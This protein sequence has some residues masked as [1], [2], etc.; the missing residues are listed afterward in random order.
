MKQKLLLLLLL[1]S[2]SLGLYAQPGSLDASFD[3]GTG[4]NQFLFSSA[5][6]PDG[7][8]IIGGRFTSYNGTTRNSIARLNDDGSLDTSFD[9]G[10]GANQFV[11]TSTLQPDGKIIIGGA[12]TSYG[13]TALNYIARLNADGSLDTS[14]DP[15]T[16]ADGVVIVAAIQPDGKI[17]IAG[18]F[19]SYNGT[20]RNKIARLNADGS[21]DTSF[22][23]GT[24]ADELILTA[25]L[26]S[27][28]KIIIG[29]R[30]TSYDGRTRN[31]IARLNDDGSL[32]TS[33][34]ADADGEVRTT[35]IQSNGKI[36]IGGSF[37]SYNGTP[38]NRSARL[39][40]DGSLDTS[41]DPGTGP[42]SDILIT[43][44]Q[45][46]G[47]V[48]IGGVFT[49]FGGTARNFVARLNDD[50]S[51]DTSFDTG[52]KAN[53]QVRTAAVQSDGKIIIG[54]FFTSYDGTTRNRIARLNGEDC[55]STPI[56]CPSNV[57]QSNDSGD[58]GAVVNFTLPTGAT[59]TPSSGSFFPVGIATVNVEG[60]DGCGETSTCSFTVTINDTEKPSISCPSNTT[61]GT[62]DGECGADLVLPAPDAD[63]NCGVTQLRGRYRLVDE[64]DNPLGSYT[65]RMDDPSGYLAV[66]RYQINWRAKD[67]ANNKRSCSY[68]LTVED[69]E[70]PSAICQDVV[71]EFNGE[72]SIDLAVSQVWNEAASDDNCGLVSYVDTSPSLSI[73]C[74]DLGSIVPLTVTISDEA[75]NTA[76]CTAAVTVIG[77]PCGSS[78][79]ADN[80]SLNCL[81][82]TD[83]AYDIDNESFTI[84]ANGCW[85][86]PS[87]P[88]KGAHIYQELCGDG[89]MT[90]RLASISPEGYAGLMLRESVD[91]QARRAGA[92]KNISTRRVRGENRF[93]Y[94]GSVIKRN[95]NRSRVKWFRIVRDGDK[96]T[97]YTSTNGSYWRRL[98]RVVMSDLE[99]CVS[100]GM[101]AYSQNASSE[102]IAVFDNVSFSGSGSS[103]I[104]NENS[105][106]NSFTAFDTDL[107]IEQPDVNIFPNPSNGQSQIELNG[108]PERPAQIMVRNAF[109]KVV[110]QIEVDYPEGTV[111]PLDLQDMPA[112]LYLISVM[113][114]QQQVI[115]KKLMIQK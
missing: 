57:V 48:I 17:I 7:K 80:G 111:L 3:P 73:S 91:P 113:Q 65:S 50:G 11:Q 45:P 38:R 109:G 63:D 1:L 87:D 96:V 56:S 60:D 46:D 44:I 89:S 40:G 78:A 28:G 29:G 90:V 75:G 35:A 54:G 10:T 16:G 5:I 99:D 105:L 86:D 30:F 39:N 6:Q 74:D 108:F 9:P 14:F 79:G 33:F 32:D 93:S 68:Y 20:A 53:N 85:H 70:D 59:A 47:K 107:E 115:T 112:G 69:D 19:N 81:G 55:T 66:G 61:V 100:I 52:T 31:H 21:L 8:I 37:T 76:N 72:A 18:A 104:D 34:G 82:D 49:S 92:L 97:S 24:G 114:E 23:P 84:S 95:Y 25:A 77:L 42:N 106:P 2:S 98:Y 58:C 67:A 4:A 27:D 15:G 110:R 22:D 103:L 12:F 83:V 64:N 101:M 71:V 102:V 51:L 94:G 41:F 88:D 26:Q 62:D 36:I 43:A 13:G